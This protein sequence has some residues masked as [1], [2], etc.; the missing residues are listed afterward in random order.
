MNELYEFLGWKH[1][2]YMES[3]EV[4]RSEDFLV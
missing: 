3:K 2:F 4:D 1:N